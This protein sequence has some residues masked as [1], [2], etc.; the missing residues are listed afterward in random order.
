MTQKP[1]LAAFETLLAA[2]HS[3]RAFLPDP[4]PDADIERI[5]QAAQRSASWNNVQPWQVIVTRGQATDEFRKAIRAA[6][7]SVSHNSDIPF[8]ERYA[9]IYK[10]RRSVCG[11]ALYGAVGVVKGDREASARQTMRNF[12]L[13]DAP[14]VAIITA[15]R[16]LGTY[17]VLDCGAYIHNFMLAAE[18]MGVASIAQAA[19]AGYSAQVRAHFAIPDDRMVVCAI[20]F[21]YRDAVDPVNGYRTER[22]AL[23]DVI[24][25]R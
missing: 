20:S 12:D 10:E 8:P 21:G 18:A 16:D 24:D 23:A 13:F 4:V 2:R 14:H 22:A 11:W 7:E 15:P 5:A 17:G 6:A 3:C 9:G 1:D 25:W 19:I